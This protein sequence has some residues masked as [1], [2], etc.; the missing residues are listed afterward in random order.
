MRKSVQ[1]ALAILAA[2]PLLATADENSD[3]PVA[4]YLTD[5]R[6]ELK[7]RCGALPEVPVNTDWRQASFTNLDLAGTH[8]ELA[9]RHLYAFRFHTPS[10][11][12]DLC[13]AVRIRPGT[14]TIRFVPARGPEEPSQ[15]LYGRKLAE[16]V[17]ELGQKER[18]FEVVTSSRHGLQGDQDYIVGF[19][20]VEPLGGPILVSL[21]IIYDP[22]APDTVFPMMAPDERAVSRGLHN[23]L[24]ETLRRN[25]YVALLGTPSAKLADSLSARGLSLRST[26]GQS[27]LSNAFAPSAMFRKDGVEFF[28][29]HDQVYDVEFFA[30]GVKG[31]DQFERALPCGLTWNDAIDTVRM[32]L[33]EP[34]DQG[35]NW[36]DDAY[37]LAYFAGNLVLAVMFERDKDVTVAFRRGTGGHL[38]LVRVYDRWQAR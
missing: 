18:H 27:D 32:T 7:Q 22:V 12:G 13:W 17:P 35:D 9:G 11:C 20:C 3:A 24:P 37:G 10:P 15:K 28:F 26:A 23:V 29:R 4:S 38:K 36:N 6:R 1:V 21:N 34:D 16:D 33:G 5:V 31:F 25:P 14:R 19:E 30:K 8:F 2:H